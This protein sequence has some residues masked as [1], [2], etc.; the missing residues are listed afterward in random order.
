M[1]EDVFDLMYWRLALWFYSMRLKIRLAWNRFLNPLRYATL[2]YAIPMMLGANPLDQAKF[3]RA[4]LR[5]PLGGRR[6]IH[7]LCAKA[8]IPDAGDEFC[9]QLFG[10]YVFY[11]SAMEGD[12]PNAPGGNGWAR[13]KISRLDF[14]KGMAQT[15]KYVNTELNKIPYEYGRAMTRKQR[16]EEEKSWPTREEFVRRTKERHPEYPPEFWAPLDEAMEKY[17]EKKPSF[18]RRSKRRSRDPRPG[19]R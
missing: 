3:E 13:H 15:G 14:Y 4:L 16:R 5:L 7:D 18:P 2:L 17:K 8:L 9:E 10:H 19:C 1:Q 11:A 6:H 12:R